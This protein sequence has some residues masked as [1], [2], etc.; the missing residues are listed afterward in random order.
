MHLSHETERHGVGALAKPE[1]L[2]GRRDDSAL[3]AL[4]KDLTRACMVACFGS[5]T[6]LRSSLGFCRAL[7]FCTALRFERAL[8]FESALPFESALAL[9]PTPPPMS[10]DAPRHQATQYA[11]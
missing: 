5:G 8:R 6:I 9:N 1:L 10:Y 11:G 4:S 2:P 3:P 7:C